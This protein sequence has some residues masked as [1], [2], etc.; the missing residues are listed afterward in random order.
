[1]EKLVSNCSFFTWLIICRILYQSQITVFY[2]ITS[3]FIF[4]WKW[5]LKKI[6]L[7]VDFILNF[8]NVFNRFLLLFL[9][10][11]KTNKHKVVLENTQIWLKK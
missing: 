7:P 2:F 5:I 4:L 11:G 3:L 8:V 6:I 9:C 1:M 10:G